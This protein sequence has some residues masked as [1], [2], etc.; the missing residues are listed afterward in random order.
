M[1]VPQGIELE[2][3]PSGLGVGSTTP[4]RSPGL[5]ASTLPFAR[6]GTLTDV[7]NG[8]LHLLLD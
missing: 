1:E 5:R 3:H 6:E 4:F 8:K 2:M 7:G